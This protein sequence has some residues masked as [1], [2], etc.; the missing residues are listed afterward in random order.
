MHTQE[1]KWRKKFLRRMNSQAS[2]EK[3]SLPFPQ[4][5]LFSIVDFFI[6]L[7]RD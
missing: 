1:L 7:E 5:D 6:S 4:L 2:V 3:K